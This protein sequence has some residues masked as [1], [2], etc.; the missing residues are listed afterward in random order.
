MCKPK[1]AGFCFKHILRLAIV[2]SRNIN[3]LSCLAPGAGSVWRGIHLERGTSRYN[4]TEQKARSL[5][6]VPSNPERQPRATMSLLV[7]PLV[8]QSGAHLKMAV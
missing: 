2:P 1:T 4:R 5:S 7:P 6:A 3:Q 8:P